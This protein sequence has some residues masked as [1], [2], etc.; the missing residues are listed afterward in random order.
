MLHMG[1]SKPFCTPNS[2]TPTAD[3]TPPPPYPISPYSW[4]NCLFP[5]LI[6]CPPQK[7]CPLFSFPPI[8]ENGFSEFSRLVTVSVLLITPLALSVIKSVFPLQ[9][10]ILP[11]FFHKCSKVNRSTDRQIGR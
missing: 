6:S 9:S 2:G 1:Y 8:S 3:R 10:L 11:F 7:C 4:Q 5:K